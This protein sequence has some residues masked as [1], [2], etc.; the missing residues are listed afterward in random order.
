ML[1]FAAIIPYSFTNKK[2]P[3]I[4]AVASFAGDLYAAKVET[5]LA[6]DYSDAGKDVVVNTAPEFSIAADK[7]FT[8][9]GDVQ[10]A[11]NLQEGRPQGYDFILKSQPLSAAVQAPLA[12]LTQDTPDVHL[13]PITPG[14][15][16]LESQTAFGEHLYHKIADSKK[17]F[18]LIC[19]T[20][21]L[22]KAKFK[23]TAIQDAIIESIK[24]ADVY[25]LLKIAKSAP[26]DHGFDL[27]PL[28]ILL[29][30][31]KTMHCQPELMYYQ[32]DEGL[33]TL[34]VNIQV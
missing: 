28:L 5:L 12:L 31:I 25:E 27:R 32:T 13:L 26:A 10:F 4:L 3:A 6:L 22:P 29:A 23:K 24:Q 2:S 14:S 8:R 11:Y 16:S 7:P 21:L 15:S 33:G 1:A 19:P 18:G 17:R 9:K 30:T 20:P 34:V